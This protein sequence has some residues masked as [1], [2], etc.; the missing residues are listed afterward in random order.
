MRVFSV[1]RPGH[2]YGDLAANTLGTKTVS[3][4]D[5][6]QGPVFNPRYDLLQNELRVYWKS[7]EASVDGG[8]LRW[9]RE[10]D[11]AFA[12]PPNDAPGFLAVQLDL[13]RS[14]FNGTVTPGNAE[15][16]VENLA[17]RLGAPFFDL[18]KDF[19]G[20]LKGRT[21]DFSFEPGM[22]LNVTDG[23]PLYAEAKSVIRRV[24][25]DLKA[26]TTSVECGAPPTL[27]L[28]DPRLTARL[29]NGSEAQDVGGQD[30]GFE[31]NPDDGAGSSAILAANIEGAPGQYTGDG[32][33]TLL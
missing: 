5:F 18:W 22:L 19:A 3:V 14:V 27:W 28:H 33:L 1:L 23:D 21:C 20:T 4:T 9:K 12:S 2:G 8:Q 16:K 26:G 29:R 15:L 11:P 32:T 7:L 31:N 24:V 10:V 13:R 30:Y 25:H 17:L 6:E